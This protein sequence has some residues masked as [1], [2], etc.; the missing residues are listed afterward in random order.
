MQGF[1]KPNIVLGP[2]ELLRYNNKN[3]PQLSVG[4]R[5]W[6]KHAPRSSEGYWGS[7]RGTELQKNEQAKT[8]ADKLI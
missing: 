4:A 1:S 8:V 7:P 5:A 2:E 3:L 6:C